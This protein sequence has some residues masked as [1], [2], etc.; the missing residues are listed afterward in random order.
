MRIVLGMRPD[1]DRPDPHS[2]S[3]P[4]TSWINL[5]VYPNTDWAATTQWDEFLNAWAI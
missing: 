1:E 5:V 3:S 4:I 2:R